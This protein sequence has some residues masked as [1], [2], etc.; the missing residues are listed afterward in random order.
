M[1]LNPGS[2]FQK[3]IPIQPLRAFPAVLL[4]LHLILSGCAYYHD[5]TPATRINYEDKV[6]HEFAMEA[7]GV[8][9][10]MDEPEVLD[11]VKALGHRIGGELDGSRIQY[12]FFAVRD[13]VMNAF[14]V[15]GGYIYMYAGLLARV[16]SVDELAG[17]M[18]HEIGHVEGNHFIR[19]Q[20]KLD[21]TNM[22]V[23]AATI[24]AGVL[25][26]GE[27][28][29][30]VGTLAQATQISASLYYSREF[31]RE[32]D[33]TSIRLAHKAGF[34]PEGI[35]SMFD[36][37]HAQSRLNASEL[38]PYFS[39]HP[40]PVERIYEVQSWI[41]AIQLPPPGRREIRGFDLARLTA[42]L[43]T[44]N[45]D[46]ILEELL[47]GTGKAP[48]NAHAQFLLGYFYLKRGDLPLAQVHLEK[49]LR[50]DGSVNEHALY[51]ARALQL[52]GQVEEAGDLYEKVLRRDPVRRA[53]QSSGRVKEAEILLRRVMQREPEN[54]LAEVFYADL[55]A[56]TDNWDQ[57]LHHYRK[58]LV[59]APDSSFA[60]L[61]LGM[62]YGRQG[63]I[64]KSY[65]ELG[66]ADKCAGRYLKALYYFN[67]AVKLL[68][69]KSREAQA[70]REEIAW[71]EE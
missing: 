60:H 67:K 15:P 69:H 43:R 56:Q 55:K 49:A 68:P 65:Y 2:R 58:A 6:G 70:A 41:G 10:L 71:L 61:S 36:T 42:R 30:A 19:G 48:K 11:F 32:A 59:L 39:T 52:S 47:A 35:T 38:P 3:K 27:S 20:K 21:V 66:L 50:M 33:R 5:R 1:N 28:A 22:A 40:L 4:F 13:P 64:G 44:E 37:F 8:L 26:G 46:K 14:A 24:L 31:E 25:G 18:A 51:L 57:A 9:R 29:A 7:S 23:I 12:R 34:D 16:G 17:V 62:A 54:S 53:V 45:D 63:E